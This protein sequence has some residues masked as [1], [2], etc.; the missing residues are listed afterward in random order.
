[1]LALNQFCHFLKGHVCYSFHLTTRYFVSVRYAHG[2]CST[3]ARDFFYSFTRE[4]CQC[5]RQKPKRTIHSHFMLILAVAMY[6]LCCVFLVSGCARIRVRIICVHTQ[7]THSWN[8]AVREYIWESSGYQR[9]VFSSS[10]SLPWIFVF[11]S[12]TEGKLFPQF[13]KSFLWLVLYSVHMHV[14]IQSH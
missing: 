1:M 3:I 4:R 8:T 2:Q 14:F 13:V 12:W 11:I 10:F 7:K 5:S 6:S 9:G